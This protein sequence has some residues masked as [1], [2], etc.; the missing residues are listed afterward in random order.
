MASLGSTNF[1]PTNQFLRTVSPRGDEDDDEGIESLTKALNIIFEDCWH[2]FL[3]DDELYDQMK[4]LFSPS[5]WGRVAVHSDTTLYAEAHANK[6]ITQLIRSQFS[7]GTFEVK[8]QNRMRE[9]K[10]DGSGKAWA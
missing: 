6:S 8:G 7:H 4:W 3:K 10:N 2:G 9:Y 1:S 5:L